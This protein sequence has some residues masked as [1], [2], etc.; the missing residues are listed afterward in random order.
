MKKRIASVQK[1]FDGHEFVDDNDVGV[2]VVVTDEDDEDDD[3]VEV[4]GVAPFEHH[5]VLSGF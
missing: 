5:L 2:A 4:E 1:K 3:G